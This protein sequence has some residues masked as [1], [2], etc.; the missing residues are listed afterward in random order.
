VAAALRQV[1]EHELRSGCIF[2]VDVVLRHVL[3]WLLL[4]P[5]SIPA[6]TETIPSLPKW[7]QAAGL[8]VWPSAEAHTEVRCM[9]T[10]TAMAESGRLHPYYIC[11]ACLA[12]TQPLAALHLLLQWVAA[13]GVSTQDFAAFELGF[14]T[15]L[16]SCL[17]ALRTLTESQMTNILALLK[18]VADH[19]RLYVDYA[20]PATV[21]PLPLPELHSKAGVLFG[22]TPDMP[23]LPLLTA[24]ASQEVPALL[25]APQSNSSIFSD[26]EPIDSVASA[27]GASAPELGH[28]EDVELPHLPLWSAILG[29]HALYSLAH[30]VSSMHLAP[31][32]PCRLGALLFRTQT[33]AESDTHT[34]H[35]H[36][37][38]DGI[39]KLHV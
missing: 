24:Q 28:H 10:P 22:A 1:V 4:R 31:S 33:I 7:A 11:V 39:S 29:A 6:D 2:M 34:I 12:P 16:E 26:S 25:S 19:L 18:L 9:C 23:N 37:Q 38:T 13:F 5:V 20:M 36:T 27:S 32:H 3:P 14:A 15:Q 35:T 30:A 17:V 21:S 8:S